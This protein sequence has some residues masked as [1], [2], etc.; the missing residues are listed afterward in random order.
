MANAPPFSFEEARGVGLSLSAVQRRMLLDLANWE[1]SEATNYNCGELVWKE[2][3]YRTSWS[4]AYRYTDR[5]LATKM[6][7][8][9]H[10]LNDE[11]LIA[12]YHGTN[13]YNL[14]AIAALREIEDR[15][16]DL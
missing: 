8:E 5:G 14:E 12:L 7:L 9:M 2:L 1:A 6:A 16:L 13:G 4:P 10:A 11:A 3:I 15:W